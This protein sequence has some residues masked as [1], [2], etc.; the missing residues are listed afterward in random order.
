[1]GNMTGKYVKHLQRD[2]VKLVGIFTLATLE[3]VKL[4]NCARAPLKPA[5]SLSQLRPGPETLWIQKSSKSRKMKA[6][7]ITNTIKRLW[8]ALKPSNNPFNALAEHPYNDSQGNEDED[9]LDIFPM[10]E[11]Y[12]LESDTTLVISTPGFRQLAFL[13]QG[14]DLDAHVP[15]DN[16]SPH[17]KYLVIDEKQM[18]TAKI[19]PSNRPTPE[20][21]VSSLDIPAS[22]TVIARPSYPPS[23]ISPKRLIRSHKLWK[24]LRWGCYGWRE[25][26][27]DGNLHKKTVLRKIS[28]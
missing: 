28:F 14:E 16:G 27:G 4:R 10:A 5:G 6:A 13:Q 9:D 23:P 21:C 26:R 19:T 15:S 12:K 11:E 20:G 22:A 8:D 1:M 2:L 17:Y 3:L 7:P 25:V 18:Y 24:T